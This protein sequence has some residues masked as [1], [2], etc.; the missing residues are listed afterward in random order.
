VALL[1]CEIGTFLAKS[2]FIVPNGNVCIVRTNLVVYENS[3]LLQ[4]CTLH[5]YHRYVDI[6]ILYHQTMFVL[7]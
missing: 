3:R 1:P 6:C 7:T 2:S 5:M 4:A